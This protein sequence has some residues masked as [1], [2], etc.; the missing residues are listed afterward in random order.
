[1]QGCSQLPFVHTVFF[2]F[3]FTVNGTIS[4]VWKF[5]RLKNKGILVGK[6]ST[7]SLWMAGLLSGQKGKPIFGL[8]II[9]Y[10]GCNIVIVKAWFYCIFACLTSTHI[11]I[12]PVIQFFSRTGDFTVHWATSLEEREINKHVLQLWAIMCPGKEGSESS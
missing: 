9:G 6:K 1:M 5:D 2:L 12:L 3:V 11:K 10:F 8:N 4:L 7:F